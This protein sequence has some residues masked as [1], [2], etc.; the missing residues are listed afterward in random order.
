MFGWAAGSLPQ[1]AHRTVLALLSLGSS[2]S[3]NSGTQLCLPYSTAAVGENESRGSQEETEGL[4]NPLF[5]SGTRQL[6][7]SLLFLWGGI[8]PDGK[9]DQSVSGTLFP[10]S[11]TRWWNM[12]TGLTTTARLPASP[13]RPAP[14]C[15]TLRQGNATSPSAL[16]SEGT[17]P[18]H[19][20]W[21]T[22]WPPSRSWFL[23]ISV[24]RLKGQHSSDA[25]GI[26]PFYAC[27]SSSLFQTMRKRAVFEDRNLVLLPLHFSSSHVT[28]RWRST[29]CSLSSAEVFL[30][31]CSPCFRDLE[32]LNGLA[33]SKSN[34]H[35]Y[36]LNPHYVWES[37][38]IILNPLINLVRHMHIIIP[39]LPWEELAKV[40]EQG[41]GEAGIWT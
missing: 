34:G 40:T 25:V 8:S 11:E 26:V 32:K 16:S 10:P 39:I 3:P 6:G 2:L 30:L 23:H 13:V 33:R 38:C 36:L 41:S 37:V 15:P 9:R 31:S 19:L 5:S 1:S 4:N 28:E 14:S 18:L 21:P 35:L 27:F 24:F 22:F 29:K 12:R 17:F 20:S 7:N